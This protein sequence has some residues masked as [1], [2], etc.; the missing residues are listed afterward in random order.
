[1][2]SQTAKCPFLPMI[3]EKCKPFFFYTTIHQALTFKVHSAPFN[4]CAHPPPLLELYVNSLTQNMR[5]EKGNTVLTPLMFNLY[6][7]VLTLYSFQVHSWSVKYTHVHFLK[8]NKQRGVATEH[9]PA[10]VCRS[11]APPSGLRWHWAGTRVQIWVCTNEIFRTG[12]QHLGYWMSSWTTANLP[13]Q[14]QI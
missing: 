11:P 13:N 6:K 3:S 4:Q 5:I 8:R 9:P 1:M 12:K 14:H 2:F 10:S 7:N